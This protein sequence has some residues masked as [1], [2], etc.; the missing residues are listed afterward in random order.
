MHIVEKGRFTVA[1]EVRK[2]ANLRNIG[3]ELNFVSAKV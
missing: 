2:A 3:R 1:E